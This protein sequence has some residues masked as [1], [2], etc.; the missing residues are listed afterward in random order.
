M[1]DFVEVNPRSIIETMLADFE[2]SYGEP[3]MP[4]DERYLFLQQ[5][6]QVVVATKALINST[7]SANLL[8]Y[9]AGT[10]LDEYGLQYDVARLQAQ[11]ARTTM[12]FTLSSVMAYDTMIPKGTRITPDGQLNF[13]TDR[14]CQIAL[15]QTTAEVTTTAEQQGIAYNGFI[16]GQIKHIVDPIPYISSAQNID[17]S[18]GGSDTET[19]DSYRDRIMTSWTKTST[20]GS[21]EGYEYYARA[22]S[23]DIAD[24]SITSPSGG[25]VNIYVLTK[26]GQP[27]QTL[28]KDIW[29]N[30]SSDKRRP[31]TDLVEVLPASKKQ[32]DISLI[33]YIS[34]ADAA[35]ESELKKAVEQAAAEFTALQSKNLGGSLNPDTLRS[36]IFRAGGYKIDIMAPEFAVLASHE[37]AVADKVSVSYGGL[38]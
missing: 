6:A 22:T 38:L 21:I 9:G 12:R 8:R 5:L 24:V 29:N 32:Y 7:A 14:D 10:V 4:G 34:R 23:A 17:A 13:L 26:S 3:L 15:G 25:R 36:M 28:L 31:L 18:S 19:D 11:K 35:S 30:V 20:A 27:S 33:Y 37:Y 1:I 16:A 2:K